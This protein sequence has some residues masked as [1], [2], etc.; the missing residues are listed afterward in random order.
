MQEFLKYFCR[1][2]IG[3]IVRILLITQRVDEFLLN[4]LSSMMSH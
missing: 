2:K 4:A 3:A 1:C